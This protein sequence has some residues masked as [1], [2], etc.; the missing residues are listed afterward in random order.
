MD[1]VFGRIEQQIRKKDTIVMPEEDNEILRN[2][3]HLLWAKLDR[4]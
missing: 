4:L 3:G 1:R 2:H